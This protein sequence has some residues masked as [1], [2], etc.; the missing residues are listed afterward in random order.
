MCSSIAEETPHGNAERT[1]E[2]DPERRHQAHLRRPHRRR[3]HHGGAGR[4]GGVR[5]WRGRRHGTAGG[6]AASRR[7]GFGR[8]RRL[9]RHSHRLHRDHAAAVAFCPHRR[10]AA[11]RRRAGSGSAYRT[12]AGPPAVKHP[13][14]VA[15]AALALALAWLWA[16]VEL[17]YGGDWTA[18]YYT[19]DRIVLPPALAAEE[20]VYRF[21]GSAGYDGQFYHLIAHDPLLRHGFG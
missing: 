3:R 21:A 12:D 10:Q 19:G 4:Q 5:L 14:T 9:C 18:L 17:N 7:R 6:R 2:P 16:T 11:H 20:N 13:L 1:R 15:G 8:R